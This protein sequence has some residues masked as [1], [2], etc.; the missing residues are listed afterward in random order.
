MS[1][2]VKMSSLFARYAPMNHSHIS[3]F[4]NQIPNVDWQTCLPKFK[5]QKSDD[6]ALHLVRF[7]MNI[8]ELGVELHED[9]LMKMFM[10]SLEVDA[11]SW[12]EGL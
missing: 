6:A 7:H 10:V 3:S 8:H 9:S 12:Y 11:R 1:S 5:N 4:P 2:L